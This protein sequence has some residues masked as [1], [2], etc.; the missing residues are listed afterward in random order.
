MD[1]KRCELIVALDLPTPAEARN[2]LDRLEGA[3]KYVKVG[4]RLYAM[5]GLPF[6]KE[7]IAMGYEL[8]LDLKLHDI[9]NTVASAVEPLSELGLWALTIHSSGGY[10]MMA[11]SV[12]MRDKTKS[13]MKLLGITVLTSL[14]GELWSDVH[15]GCDMREALIGRAETASRAGL[16]GIVCSPLDLELL[17]GRAENLLRVV[18]GIRAKKVSTE[19]QTRVATAKDAALAGASCIVVGRP[20]L[21]APDPVAAALD[22]IK[23]LEE[24]SR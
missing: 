19:D 7:I 22:I 11:R 5:G 23:T 21:E 8:F 9:P 6:V 10:E 16:D 2:F 15:P 20:V 13:A 18:P 4:P 24:V 12:A 17:R 1:K 3:T 14:G